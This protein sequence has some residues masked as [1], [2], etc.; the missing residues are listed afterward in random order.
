MSSPTENG[1]AL[2]LI[3]RFDPNDYA[4]AAALESAIE[5]GTSMFL[6]SAAATNFTPGDMAFATK[7]GVRALASASVVQLVAKGLT[8]LTDA[9]FR[10]VFAFPVGYFAALAEHVGGVFSLTP[11]TSVYDVGG[12]RLDGI[13][14]YA[15]AAFSKTDASTLVVYVGSYDNTSGSTVAINQSV[16]EA[17]DGTLVDFRVRVTATLEIGEVVA[18]RTRV[19]ANGTLLADFNDTDPAIAVG[20]AAV[21]GGMA[22]EVDDTDTFPLFVT[23]AEIYDAT[24]NSDP[25]PADSISPELLQAI[26][27]TE[28]RELRGA[29]QWLMDAFVGETPPELDAAI[30]IIGDRA[31][32][33]AITYTPP[34]LS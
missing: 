16:L 23:R 24:V 29:V 9:W 33:G 10:T 3:G 17:W 26:A 4:N 22:V 14:Y 2:G 28:S 5:A 6:P 34:G 12:S 13:D 30:R 20:W 8:P 32:A 18:I 25:W 19:Y 31:Q 1:S 27:K 15:A 11:V 21:A 7:V